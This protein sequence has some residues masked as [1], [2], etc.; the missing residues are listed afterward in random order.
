MVT[1]G[2]TPTLT[3]NKSIRY[4]QDIRSCRATLSSHTCHTAQST[5]ADG[6]WRGLKIGNDAL[7]FAIPSKIT[8]QTLW[9]PT[10]P[11]R[12]VAYG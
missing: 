1:N 12:L 11:K 6:R 3:T 5:E 2:I 9:I 8:T 10:R 4:N 7:K